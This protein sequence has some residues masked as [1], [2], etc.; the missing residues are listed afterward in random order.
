MLVRL[1]CLLGGKDTVMVDWSLYNDGSGFTDGNDNISY[2]DRAT[3]PLKRT[4]GYRHKFKVNT[5][6]M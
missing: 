6:L 1:K 4:D 3:T 2:A 5:K